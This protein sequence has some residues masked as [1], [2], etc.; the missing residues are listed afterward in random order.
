[1]LF[2]LVF[3]LAGGQAKSPPQLKTL[4]FI[5]LAQGSDLAP[6]FGDLSQSEKSLRLSHL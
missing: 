3:A 2:G 1:M 5:F 6:F 4:L